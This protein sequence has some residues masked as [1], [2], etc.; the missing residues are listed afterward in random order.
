MLV[1]TVAVCPLVDH[2]PCITLNGSNLTAMA[3][4]VFKPP[5]N[6]LCRSLAA[7]TFSRWP[8]PR[9]SSF[10]VVTVVAI[11]SLL[12]PLLA[13]MGISRAHESVPRSFSLVHGTDPRTTE[14]PPLSIVLFFDDL[15]H[16]VCIAT[17]IAQLKTLRLHV[18]SCRA[19]FPRTA[20]YFVLVHSSMSM[21]RSSG[22]AHYLIVF[23]CN[24][25]K[26]KLGKDED[27]LS[28]PLAKPGTHMSIRRGS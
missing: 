10:V 6:R 28:R 1:R 4:P 21:L 3:L 26:K 15:N 18:N 2:Q 13:K 14:D 23:I 9:C 19:P 27:L 12:L 20:Q 17:L 25:R 22:A 5:G 8:R 24:C 7:P 16:F 11:S